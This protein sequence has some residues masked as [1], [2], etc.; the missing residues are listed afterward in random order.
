MFQALPWC[1]PQVTTTFSRLE[2]EPRLTQETPWIP[3]QK[4]VRRFLKKRP[5][6]KT[7]QNHAPQKHH[8]I[9]RAT[10]SPSKDAAATY[11]TPKASDGKLHVLGGPRI[12]RTDGP[13]ER[14]R[15]RV[16]GS[17]PRSK[18]CLEGRC[19]LG[20]VRSAPKS[21]KS[22]ERIRRVHPKY[23]SKL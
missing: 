20:G 8:Q 1:K 21:G 3:H 14:R 9:P 13:A 12:R 19:V 22:L 15:T 4:C 5:A 16:A 10:A 17:P 2:Q 6:P 11:R 18:K 7:A 23:T